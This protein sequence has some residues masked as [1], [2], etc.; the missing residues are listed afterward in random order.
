[1]GTCFGESYSLSSGYKTSLVSMSRTHMSI[2]FLRIVNKFHGFGQPET[3]RLLASQ[4]VQSEQKVLHLQLQGF[5]F[6]LAVSR[7]W[8]FRLISV[9]DA[10]AR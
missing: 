1:M 3:L 6:T 9:L 10:S 8:S 4:E 5:Y 7:T 2:S